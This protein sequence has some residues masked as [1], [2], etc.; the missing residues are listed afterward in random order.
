MKSICKEIDKPLLKDQYKAKLRRDF[1]SQELRDFASIFA[2]LQE[3]R[4]IADYDPQAI[5]FQSDAIGAC[6]SAEFGIQAFQNSDPDEVADV[7]ALML[8]GVRD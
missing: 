4:E 5:V 7:L 3:L 6:G 2:G 1:V 8:A